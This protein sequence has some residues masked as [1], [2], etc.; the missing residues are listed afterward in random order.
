MEVGRCHLVWILSVDEYLIFLLKPGIH[1]G[2]LEFDETLGAT[3]SVGDC[4]RVGTLVCVY[5]NYVIDIMGDSFRGFLFFCRSNYTGG[6]QEKKMLIRHL[7]YGEVVGRVVTVFPAE[8]TASTTS[9][10]K[11]RLC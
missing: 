6:R 8:R 5:A 2:K 9:L 3:I 1:L 4:G 10:M 7:R 11:R